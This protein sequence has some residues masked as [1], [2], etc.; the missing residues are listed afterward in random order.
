LRAQDPWRV[1]TVTQ[2]QFLVFTITPIVIAVLGWIITEIV[3]RQNR[4][5]R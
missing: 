1:E 3:V 5:G 2:E 4:K